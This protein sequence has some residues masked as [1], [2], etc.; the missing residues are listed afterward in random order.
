MKTPSTIQEVQFLDLKRPPALRSLVS[1]SDDK[2][3][4]VQVATQTGFHVYLRQ[5][6]K[7]RLEAAE[8]VPRMQRFLKAAGLSGEIAAAIVKLLG[9][10]LL[11][12]QGETLHLFVPTAGPTATQ[13][14]T[15]TL[16]AALVAYRQAFEKHI[17]PVAPEDFQALR[18]TMD[19]GLSLIVGTERNCDDSLISLAPA[20]N[21]PAKQFAKPSE[22]FPA[23]H[24]RVPSRLLKPVAALRLDTSVDDNGASNSWVNINLATAASKLDADATSRAIGRSASEAAANAVSRF[25]FRVPQISQRAQITNGSLTDAVAAQGWMLRAD[26]DGFSSMVDDAFTT[27]NRSAAIKDLVEDFLSR[28]EDASRF[29]DEKTGQLNIAMPWAG[30][31]ACRIVL[32]SENSNYHDEAK[33]RPALMGLRWHNSSLHPEWLVAIAGG[34]AD[35]GDGRMLV[36]D[37]QIDGNTYRIAAG[38]PVRRSKQGE[39]DSGRKRTETVLHKLDA[40]ALSQPWLECFKP[41]DTAPQHRFATH[42]DLRAAAGKAGETSAS[43]IAVACGM[44]ARLSPR[45]YCHDNN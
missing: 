14:E 38:W 15:A 20:A 2:P 10:R 22:V 7:L 25:Q 27:T 29:D 12:H 4:T 28:M 24:A 45:P 26:L 3:P 33:Q 39:Q 23:D 18:A 19:H 41:V 11:E 36:S 40:A 13:N 5:R 21:R 44:P 43:R 17:R 31:C 9:G 1:L 30:D 35:E 37:I 42:K 6:L 34:N 16:I 32:V 8:S